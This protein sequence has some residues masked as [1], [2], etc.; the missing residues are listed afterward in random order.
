MTISPRHL[1][2]PLALSFFLNACSFTPYHLEHK[3]LESKS[4]YV[5]TT[6]AQPIFEHLIAQSLRNYHAKVVENNKDADITIKLLTLTTTKASPSNTS[7]QDMRIYPL[8]LT[9][10]YSLIKGDKPVLANQKITLRRNFVVH[11]Q[12]ASSQN[13]LADNITEQMYQQAADQILQQLAIITPS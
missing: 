7:S 3:N 10:S 4:V 5:Q 2:L 11:A 6:T 13:D 1:F 8:T 9:L 12:K